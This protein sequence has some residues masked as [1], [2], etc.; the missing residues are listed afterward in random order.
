MAKFCKWTW[1]RL[2]AD[3]NLST[4]DE[5]VEIHEEDEFERDRGSSLFGADEPSVCGHPAS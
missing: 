2:S 5:D 4:G 1:R 3:P